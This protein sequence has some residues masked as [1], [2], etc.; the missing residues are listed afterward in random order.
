MPSHFFPERP[1]NRLKSRNPR[2]VVEEA[3]DDAP[4]REPEAQLWNKNEQ[5]RPLESPR[6]SEIDRR[7]IGISAMA[8]ADGEVAD[9]DIHGF[10]SRLILFD[11][12]LLSSI[13]LKEI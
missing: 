9:V 4:S 8:A 1:D 13:R 12:Y 3:V 6:A 7:L 11:K 10:I 5:S 2:V